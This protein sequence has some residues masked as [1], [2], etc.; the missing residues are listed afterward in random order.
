MRWAK[1]TKAIV[2]QSDV[3]WQIAQSGE[4]TQLAWSWVRSAREDVEFVILNIDEGPL[5][6]LALRKSMTTAPALDLLRE[7]LIHNGK[8]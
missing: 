3:I 1:R 4:R 5:A 2:L 6:Q 8:L 7:F